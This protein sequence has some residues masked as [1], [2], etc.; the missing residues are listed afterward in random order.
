MTA[1][2]GDAAP[3]RRR[4]AGRRWA[5]LLAAVLVAGTTARLGVW[6]LDRA[7][8]KEALQAALDARGALPPLPQAEL[9]T[10][11]GDA[12]AQHHRRVVLRGRWLAERTV[13]LDNRQM[14]GRPGF[15]VVTPL[16]WPGGAVAVQ[17][18]WVPRDNDVRTRLPA[19]VTPAG[20]V[21]VRG[22]IAPPPA[23]LH[24]F[25]NAAQGPIRQNLD[26]A[27]YGREIGAT[28]LPLSV[29][30]E[31]EAP[32]AAPAS[33]APAEPPQAR[34]PP[35]P[36]DGLLR[37][38]PPPALDVQK[39]YGYAFQWFALSAVTT[40]LY[41]WFQILQPRRRRAVRRAD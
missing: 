27:A 1:A 10:R 17:R 7:A 8:Q 32:S 16:V 5:V 21:E 3:P 31:D 20:E 35:A 14:G 39:H 25:E 37:R 36:S 28:L 12:A 26:L 38:W 18:G 19:I 22:R 11:P 30:Q 6:Q 13:W 41:V 2:A 24:E 23:R 15:Y 40:G 34:L 33:T 4:G 29:R 9:A